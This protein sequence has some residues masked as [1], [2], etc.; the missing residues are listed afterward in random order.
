M[1]KIISTTAICLALSATTCNAVSSEVK[2]RGGLDFQSFYLTSSGAESQKKATDKKKGLGFYSYGDI[3]LDY[4]LVSD[5]GLKYGAKVGLEITS[6]N[7]RA[8]PASVYLQSEFGKIEGGSDKSAGKKMR[9]TGYTASCGSA[10]SWDT[11]VKPTPDKKKLSYVTNFCSFL[12]SKM[13]TAGKVEYSRKITYIT[14]NFSLGE[15]N[16]L[17]L[18][19]SY[20]PDSSNMGA[21]DVSDFTLHTPV[22]SSKFKFAI[23][24]GISYGATH[25]INFDDNTSLRTAFVGETGK[26]LAFDANTDK[27]SDIKFKKLNNYVLGTEFKYKNISLSGSYGNYNKSLSSK[28]IDKLG[29]KTFLYAFGGKYTWNKFGFSLTHFHSD[30]KKNKL[31]TYTAGV[32]YNIVKGVKGYLQTTYYKT[33]GK[34]FNNDNQLVFDKTHGNLVILGAKLSF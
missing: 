14:P 22:G 12:D 25:K 9:I 33:K 15:N 4:M 7:D 27:R 28:E 34:Y 31:D 17:Q 2:L 30:H 3:Y 19:I 21:G 18:G 1:K 26:P 8:I 6:K 32:D 5:S 23:K 29:Q 16:S 13:R 10:S 20:V 24:D 11:Y